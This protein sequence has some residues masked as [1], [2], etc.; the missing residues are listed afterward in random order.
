MDELDELPTHVCI[1]VVKALN[2]R[3]RQAIKDETRSPFLAFTTTSQG[4]KGTY[5][6]IM[7]F[8]KI[9]MSYMIVRGRTRDN[10]YLQK[11]YVEDMYKMYN[12]KER[13]SVYLEGEFVSIDSGLVFP[14]YNPCF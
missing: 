5:Q 7:N 9:G 12:E 13:Q 11:E 14:D 1:A 4:L 6:T 3:C 2:D 10:I 8:R